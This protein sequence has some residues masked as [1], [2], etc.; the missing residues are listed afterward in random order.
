M[1]TSWAGGTA[2]SP[3]ELVLQDHDAARRNGNASVT[4]QRGDRLTMAFS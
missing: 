1:L 3:V 2:S 4:N